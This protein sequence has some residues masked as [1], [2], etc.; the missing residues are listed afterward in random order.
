MQTL[1]TGHD[2]LRSHSD[3][4][5]KRILS[6]YPALHDADEAASPLLSRMVRVPY[7]AQPIAIMGVSKR[8][9]LGRNANCFWQVGLLGQLASELDVSESIFLAGGAFPRCHLSPIA[10][11]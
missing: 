3:E 11:I 7:P 1:D 4:I 6:S 8:W 2:Y 5:G 10:T 9:Q